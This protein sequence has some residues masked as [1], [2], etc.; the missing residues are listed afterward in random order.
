MLFLKKK[1]KKES[2]PLSKCEWRAY[3][4]KKSYNFKTKRRRKLTRRGRESTAREFSRI[5]RLGADAD[6]C[7]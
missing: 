6:M 4:V 3:P 5:S 1:K 2:C 7:D